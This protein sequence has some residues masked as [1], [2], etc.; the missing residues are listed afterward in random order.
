MWAYQFELRI[1]NWGALL[2][3]WSP[4]IALEGRER[5]DA[6][7]A[8]HGAAVL[9]VAHTA[10]NSNVVKRALH[11]L[12]YALHHVS[13]P[14]H[15]FSKTRFGI[16]FLNVL[17][18]RAEDRDLRSRIVIGDAR[19]AMRRA[20]ARLREP[21]SL[22]SITAGSWEGAKLLRVAF[23]DA[24]ILL[25]RGAAGLARAT[26]APLLPVF[27]ARTGSDQRFVVRIG[28]PIPVDRMGAKDAALLAA[29]A[30]FARR[31]E[32]FVAHYPDQWRGWT[33]LAPAATPR[34]GINTCAGRR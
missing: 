10:C 28:P 21:G 19:A 30:E 1:Q 2:G 26:R 17:R 29:A 20:L 8:R 7:L 22:V 32:D 13:R 18:R 33:S 12:G 16:R 6:A 27:A 25:G 9:W 23:L 3:R 31:T 24:D 4:A 5:I 14:E 11:D 15:G 34:D